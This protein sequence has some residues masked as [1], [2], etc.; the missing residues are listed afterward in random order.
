LGNELQESALEMQNTLANL[1]HRPT[2]QV[3]N[4]KHIIELQ[5]QTAATQAKGLKLE[6]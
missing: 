2:K 5:R 3:R 1:Q 6:S 4:K